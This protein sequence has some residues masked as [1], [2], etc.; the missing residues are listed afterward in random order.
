MNATRF[1][2]Y[3]GTYLNILTLIFKLGRKVFMNVTSSVSGLLL[4]WFHLR[5]N[6]NKNTD[7]VPVLVQKGH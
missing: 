7:H 4:S 6:K 3:R 5:Y 1:S 2:V